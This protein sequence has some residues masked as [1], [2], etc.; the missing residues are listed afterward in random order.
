MV[1]KTEVV[2]TIQATKILCE[3]LV[4]KIRGKTTKVATEVVVAIE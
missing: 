3:M 1:T 2:T 4:L